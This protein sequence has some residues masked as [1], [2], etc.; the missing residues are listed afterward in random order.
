[1]C[2]LCDFSDGWLTMVVVKVMS[3]AESMLGGR[4]QTSVL[5][6]LLRYRCIH[7]IMRALALFS[8][9][10]VHRHDTKSHMRAHENISLKVY[11]PASP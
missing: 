10:C 5:A 2:G 3:Y 4:G 6:V 9:V 7:S 11:V 8:V 1:M